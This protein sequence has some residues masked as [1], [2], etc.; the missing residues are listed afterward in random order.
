MRIYQLLVET[1]ALS[2][3]YLFREHPSRKEIISLFTRIWRKLCPNSQETS[4]DLLLTAYLAPEEPW[5]GLWECP[6]GKLQCKVHGVI[7]ADEIA[8][9]I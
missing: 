8:K 4:W 2:A 6:F 7:E 5:L 1:E 3:S 9:E